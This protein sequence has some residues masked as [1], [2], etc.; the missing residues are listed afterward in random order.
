MPDEIRAGESEE[1]GK[2]WG[3]PIAVGRRK[4]LP[5]Q[6]CN[7]PWQMDYCNTHW[8][9]HSNCNSHWQAY[10]NCNTHW[11]MHSNCN[12]PWQVYSNSNTH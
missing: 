8:Q 7:P 2:E 3:Q 5:H 11:R 4:R 9:V 12:T 1:L 6:D 10:S